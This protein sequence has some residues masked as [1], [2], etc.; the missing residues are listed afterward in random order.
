MKANATGPEERKSSG[1]KAVKTIIGIAVIVL[2]FLVFAIC[3]GD[4]ARLGKYCSGKDPSGGYIYQDCM[5]DGWK[6]WYANAHWMQ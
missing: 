1:N 3:S 2:I 4:R 6:D 5:D